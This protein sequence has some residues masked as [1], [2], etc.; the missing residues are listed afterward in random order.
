V[1]GALK[2]KKQVRILGLAPLMLQEVLACCTPLSQYLILFDYSDDEATE[3]D[4]H[5]CGDKHVHVRFGALTTLLEMNYRTVEA[6]ILA[7]AMDAK[8]EQALPS[9]EEW[10]HAH[11]DLVQR[12]DASPTVAV[13]PKELQKD[14]RELLVGLLDADHAFRHDHYQMLMLDLAGRPEGGSK[15]ARASREDLN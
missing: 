7:L 4:L 2:M 6:F 10:K 9:F 1:E 12:F 5:V 8:Q 15:K 3:C 11:A 13:L 14:I